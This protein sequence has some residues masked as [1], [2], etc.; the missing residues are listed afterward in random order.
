MKLYDHDFY[1]TI[2]MLSNQ[3]NLLYPQESEYEVF[4]HYLP[5]NDTP[6]E[7]KELVGRDGYLEVQNFKIQLTNLKN[8]LLGLLDKET[9]LFCFQSQPQHHNISQLYETL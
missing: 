3:P 7:A 4:F 5:K 8:P 2:G 1:S 6:A 9:I